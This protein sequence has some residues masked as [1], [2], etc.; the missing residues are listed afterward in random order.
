MN[1]SSIISGH[2]RLFD[3]YDIF[4]CGVVRFI[5]TTIQRHKVIKIDF[6]YDDIYDVL[7]PRSRDTAR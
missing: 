6:N 1:I 2:R 3:S 7:V 4:I 5:K